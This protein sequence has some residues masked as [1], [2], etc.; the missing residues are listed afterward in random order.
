MNTCLKCGTKNIESSVYC[1]NCGTKLSHILKESKKDNY[2]NKIPSSE[3]QKYKQRLYGYFFIA[4]VL[5]F[6]AI[7]IIS[8]EGSSFDIVVLAVCIIELIIFQIQITSYLKNNFENS[9]D[10]ILWAPFMHWVFLMVIFFLS[11]FSLYSIFNLTYQFTQSFVVLLSFGLLIGIF[12]FPIRYY[13]YHL[14]LK[15]AN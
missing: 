7:I 10:F 3:D 8:N 14:L 4:F 11:I 13:A 2:E 6:I 9:K 12:Y 15:K 5:D 1:Q